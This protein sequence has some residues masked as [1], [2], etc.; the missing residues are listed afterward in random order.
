MSLSKLVGML[1]DLI[2]A[3]TK[4]ISRKLGNQ[5]KDTLGRVYEYFL[6]RFASAE[7]RG[8]GEFY[9]PTSVVRLLVEMLEKDPT[10]A[11]LGLNPP[12]A[13]IAEKQWP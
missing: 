13:T 12:P 2:L 3:D 8:G 9:T 6:S 4:S 10:E 7:G 5:D 11:S 1:T